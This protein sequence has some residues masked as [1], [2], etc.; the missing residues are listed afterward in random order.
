MAGFSAY[1]YLSYLFIAPE[2]TIPLS[3]ILSIL[4]FGLTRYYSTP[5]IEPS[6]TPDIVSTLKSSQNI[7]HEVHYKKENKIQS[8]VAFVTI[9]VLL[10]LISSFS[11]TEDFHVFTNWKDISLWN[12]IQLGAALALC[13]FIP[14]YAIVLILT[15]KYKVDRLLSFLLGYLFSIL[16]TGL[17]AYLSALTFDI[18][19]SH[20]KGLIISVY[21]SIK[22]GS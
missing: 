4:V 17:T 22:V 15:K 20:S 12:I 19:T 21:V 3:I 11:Y 6:D 2:V 1:F 7:S 8:T 14:G 9:F 13:F 5:Y 16:I 10:I 18:A